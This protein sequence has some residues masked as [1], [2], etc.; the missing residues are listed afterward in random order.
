MK[1]VAENP[2]DALRSY[3]S[4]AAFICLVASPA[5]D[6]TSCAAQV[7]A[8]SPTQPA[9]TQPIDLEGVPARHAIRWPILS[10]FLD[11]VYLVANIYPVPLSEGTAV[12]ERPIY[13]ARLPGGAIPAPPGS[14]QFIYPK[15][16]KAPNGDLH[17]VWAERD[18]V[19]SQALLWP[20]PWQNALWHAVF[21]RG[22]WSTPTEILRASALEWTT[23]DGHLTLDGAG[24]LHA[25]IW[26][27]EI[28]QTVGIVHL[29]QDATTWHVEQLPYRSVN[30]PAAILAF[31]DSLLVALVGNSFDASDTTGVTVLRST[32]QG[33]VWS[34]PVVIRRL[35]RRFASHLE[36]IRM[37]G[38]TLLVWGEKAAG[39]FAFDSIR[40]VQINDSL[41]P[42]PVAAVSLPLR[43][44]SF[45][46]AATRCNSLSLLVG[47]LSLSPLPQ[48]FEVTIAANG[49]VSQRLL[50][51]P[52]ELVTAAGVVATSTSLVAVGVI[53]SQP[54]NQIHEVMMRRPACAPRM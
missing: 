53:V 3:F 49:A 18:S 45:S 8:A 20:G 24:S 15:I 26:R 25:I 31:G 43:A 50:R 37:G 48:T 21:A 17:L 46:V 1:F 42:I 7:S 14:F 32:D 13:L 39:K 54:S 23:D 35:G 2:L 51:P 38:Q 5:A 44:N 22:R 12:G 27:A 36:F 29:R 52:E 28:G 30:E 34:A 40:V 11:T 47:T 19:V 9:W 10:S 16:L 41:R 6:I 4:T 33:R